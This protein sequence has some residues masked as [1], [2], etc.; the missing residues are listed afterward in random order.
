MRFPRCG[1]MEIEIEK[2][3]S[4]AGVFLFSGKLYVTPL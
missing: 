2:P 3:R 4:V 1:R